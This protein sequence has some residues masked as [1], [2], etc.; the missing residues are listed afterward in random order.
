MFYLAGPCDLAW[1]WYP[2]PHWYGGTNGHAEG[3]S[4]VPAS[5][6]ESMTKG[7]PAHHAGVYLDPDAGSGG[8]QAQRW[9]D[10]AMAPKPHAMLAVRRGERLWAI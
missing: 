8:G 1:W 6:S 4:A 5:N 10:D 9:A 2:M 3:R 7:V